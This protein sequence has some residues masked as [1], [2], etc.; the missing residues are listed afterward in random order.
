MV[1][2]SGLVVVVCNLL[3]VYSSLKIRGTGIVFIDFTYFVNSEIPFLKF[4]LTA[5]LATVN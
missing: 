1:M 2:K 4:V 3:E 5:L